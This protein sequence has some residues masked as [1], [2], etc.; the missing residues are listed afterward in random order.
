MSGHEPYT[1]LVVGYALDALEPGD[2]Q[3]LLTHLPFCNV[4]QDFLAD[5][6]EV[7][8]GLASDVPSEE[9]PAV[10]LENIR[11]AIA[12]TPQDV[13]AQDRAVLH[14]LDASTERRINRK[15]A[16]DGRSGSSVSPARGRRW[17]IFGPGRRVMAVA[18]ALIAVVALA[19]VGG[20]ALHAASERNNASA[21][22]RADQAVLS[23]LDNPG[24]YSVTL[25]SGGAA[26]AAAVV[27]GQDVY[28]VAHDINKNDK[29]SSIYVLWAAQSNGGMVAV[30]TFDVSK[31]GLN[32]IHMTLPNG[33]AGPERFGVTHESGRKAPAVPGATILSGTQA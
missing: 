23:H 16:G 26:S 29:T 6:R 33:I 10:L 8:A 21:T 15:A 1:E 30:G 28:L 25:T 14:E 5:M 4:C 13:S 9:P 18:A 19:G 12:E 20:Y 11:V 27:D 2:E 22:L 3:E 7:A 32:V 17:E 31:D 24:A